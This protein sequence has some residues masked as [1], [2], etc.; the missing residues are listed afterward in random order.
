MERVPFSLSQCLMC[1]GG[2][3]DTSQ[4]YSPV[5]LGVISVINSMEEEVLVRMLYLLSL[6]I[7]I[8]PVA[9]YSLVLLINLLQDKTI[10]PRLSTLHSNLAVFPPLTR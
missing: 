8:L 3:L 10:G 4:T 9:M 1:T 7:T 6:T 2:V 5:S